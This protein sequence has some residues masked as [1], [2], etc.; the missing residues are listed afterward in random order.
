M[1]QLDTWPTW[2]Y[3]VL[4]GLDHDRNNHLGSQCSYFCHLTNI[5]LAC[6]VHTE[7]E[8]PGPGQCNLVGKHC[9]TQNQAPQM[10]QADK[11]YMESED[12]HLDQPVLPGKMYKL[13]CHL[14][15]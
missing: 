7:C 11:Y 1:I 10:F 14:V 13:P 4:M 15:K 5:D 2:N 12:Q 8:N 6:T 3:M 9:K